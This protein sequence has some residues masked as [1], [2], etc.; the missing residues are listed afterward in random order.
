MVKLEN[1]VGKVE[2]SDNF[3]LK[4][5]KL[6]SLERLMERLMNNSWNAPYL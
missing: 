6:K 2:K 5:L 3:I 1:V 4:S